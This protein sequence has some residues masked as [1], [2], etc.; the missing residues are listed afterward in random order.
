MGVRMNTAGSAAARSMSSKRRRNLICCKVAGR[1]RGLCT[2]AVLIPRQALSWCARCGRAPPLL[3][4]FDDHRRMVAGPFVLARELVDHAGA[5]QG[6]QR[7]ADQDVV[8]AQALVL[9]EGQVA[10]V[11]PAPALRRLLEQAECVDEAEF[12]QALEVAAL[13]TRAMGITPPDA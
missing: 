11:P 12:E 6:L 8:D 3:A 10:V 4:Q 7:R 1:R 9:A 2:A 13:L 5:H